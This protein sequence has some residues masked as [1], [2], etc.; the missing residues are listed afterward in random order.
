[1]EL[2]EYGSEESGDEDEERKKPSEK[3]SGPKKPKW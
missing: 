2:S 3:R 1:M